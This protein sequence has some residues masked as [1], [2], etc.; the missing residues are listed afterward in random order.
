MS[1][2]KRYFKMRWF[3]SRFKDTAKLREQLPAIPLIGWQ[4][5]CQGGRRPSFRFATNRNSLLP[6]PFSKVMAQI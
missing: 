6:P 1:T 5:K 3:V 4:A 2:V